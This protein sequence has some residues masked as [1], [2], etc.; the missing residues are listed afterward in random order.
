MW[1]FG[2]IT[3]LILHPDVT[4]CSYAFNP[5]THQKVKKKT[6]WFFFSSWQKY[7]YT[8]EKKINSIFT[9]NPPFFFWTDFK[10]VFFVW[11]ICLLCA[12]WF[13]FKKQKKKRVCNSHVFFTI[14]SLSLFDYTQTLY[15]P[16]P[17]PSLIYHS[18]PLFYFCF[19]I[20]ISISVCACACRCHDSAS[21][22]PIF[23]SQFY[24]FFVFNSLYYRCCCWIII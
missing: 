12:V 11:T 16:P 6:I 22:A 14:R 4:L 23:P 8:K 7:L 2:H 9:C 5:A 10:I 3:L 13:L 24:F 19:K 21:S 15:W 1:N 18:L 17:S 20:K